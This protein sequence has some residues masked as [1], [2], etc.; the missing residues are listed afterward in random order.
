MYQN[1]C[2]PMRIRKKAKK[3][4]NGGLISAQRTLNSIKKDEADER[5]PV[6][7]LHLQNHQEDF[8]A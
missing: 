7:T 1:A 5:P 6:R 4:I 3:Y 8:L 2:I